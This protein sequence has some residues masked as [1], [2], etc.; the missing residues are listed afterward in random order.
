MTSCRA[1]ENAPSFFE[2]AF[3]TTFCPPLAA[4]PVA[5]SKQVSLVEVSPSMVMQLKVVATCSLSSSCSTPGAMAASVNMKHSIV[6]ISG[7]IMPAPLQKPLIVT[8]TSPIFAVRVASFGYVSVVKI[9]RAAASNMSGLAALARP[10]SSCENLEA[11]NG[12]P[13][14]PVEAT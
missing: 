4:A 9:A 7:A 10:S 13:I 3:A 11:S 12:S 8:S 1:A 2:L 14:T 6:A 5:N